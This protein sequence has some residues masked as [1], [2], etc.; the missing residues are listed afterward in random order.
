SRRCPCRCGWWDTASCSRA[1]VSAWCSICSRRGSRGRRRGRSSAARGALGA[2]GER[3]GRRSLS[4]RVDLDRSF[5]IVNKT[6]KDG[7]SVF[8]DGELFVQN[9]K[10]AA[11]EDFSLVAKER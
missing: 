10:N 7:V 1:G 6:G 2:G 9:L 5:Y 8:V 4:H 11:T 3:S